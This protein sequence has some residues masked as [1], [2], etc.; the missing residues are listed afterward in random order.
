MAYKLGF[1]LSLFFVVQVMAYAGDL[2]LIQGINSLLD[3]TS[4]T[5]A[6]QISHNSGITDEIINLVKTEAKA[7]I[8]A[9]SDTTPK[10][11]DV[12]IFKIYREYKPLIIS[13]SP[14][15]ISVTRSTVIGYID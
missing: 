3:A 6:R 2:T 11:G 8:V 9:V 7:D 10:V 14:M 13:D 15:V 12:F 4:L 1:L 5:A